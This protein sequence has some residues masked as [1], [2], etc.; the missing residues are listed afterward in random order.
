MFINSSANCRIF[1][2]ITGS[3]PALVLLHGFGNDH[4]MWIVVVQ[5]LKQKAEIEKAN[6]QLIIFDDLDHVGLV[7]NAPVVKEKLL[8]FINGQQLRPRQ[9]RP[10]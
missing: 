4:T 10:C 5:L 8:A 3:G 6:G 2:E 7:E 9:D 1:Y